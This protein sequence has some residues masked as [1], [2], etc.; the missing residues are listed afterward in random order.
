LFLSVALDRNWLRGLKNVYATINSHGKWS[1]GH[2]DDRE[3]LVVAVL[4]MDSAEFTNTASFEYVN[5]NGQKVERG[6]C[7]IEFLSPVHPSRRG[8]KAYPLEGKWK[9]KLVRLENSDRDSKTADMWL[10]KLV[11]PK[12]HSDHSMEGCPA[13]RMVKAEA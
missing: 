4:D 6:G 7:P 2:F 11:D 12:L 8:E 10:L 9:G 1:D 3:V 5:E 13:H